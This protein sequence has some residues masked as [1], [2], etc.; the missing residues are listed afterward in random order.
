MAAPK[1]RRR[2]FA[3]D[4]GSVGLSGRRTRRRGAQAGRSATR[5]GSGRAAGIAAAGTG[6][7]AAR[8]AA[9][10]QGRRIVFALDDGHGH[11]RGY[12]RDRRAASRGSA[13]TP[14]VQDCRNGRAGCRCGCWAWS[15]ATGHGR[16]PTS[17]CCGTCRSWNN[18]TCCGMPTASSF[19]ASWIAKECF[20]RRANMPTERT[21]ATGLLVLES[22]WLDPTERR[23]VQPACCCGSLDA[24]HNRFDRRGGDQRPGSAAGTLAGDAAGTERAA[25]SQSGTPGRVAGGQAT[26]AAHPGQRTRNRSPERTPAS[27]AGAIP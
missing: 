20:L 17:R 12:R 18:W 10:R 23:L 25:V 15:S 5:Q 2:T 4:R 8:Q 3:H 16:T 13:A 19:C 24:R 14:P 26:E 1:K 7:G 22:P 27:R 11:G 9:R 6:L 21:L